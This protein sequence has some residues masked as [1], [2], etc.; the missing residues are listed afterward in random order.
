MSRAMLLLA[1]LV[2][3]AAPQRGS[4]NLVVNGTAREGARGWQTEGAATI[5]E[6]EGVPCFVLRNK[7]SFAQ[8]I[9]LGPEAAAMYAV[10]VGRGQS[11]RINADRSITGLPYLYALVRAV[12]RRRFVAYWQGQSMRARP[13]DSRQWV[14]MWGIFQVPEG[15]A[16]ILLQLNQAEA[17]GSPQDGSAA[18]FADVQMHVFPTERAARRFVDA[19]LGR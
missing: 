11:D 15:A 19:F 14:S 3:V 9:P 6:Y 2:A 13:A 4:G 7:G 8:E 17:A 5:E 12:D 10:L 1:A 16:S 18:R